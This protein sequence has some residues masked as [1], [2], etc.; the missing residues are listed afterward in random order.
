MCGGG[1][2]ADG[3]KLH[4]VAAR[5][6]GRLAESK[7]GEDRPDDADDQLREG[8]G[9]VRVDVAARLFV[10]DVVEGVADIPAPRRIRH[11]GEGRGR[12]G[13]GGS[14]HHAGRWYGSCFDYKLSTTERICAPQQERPQE[15]NLPH[16]GQPRPASESTFK[17][18]SSRHG[19]SPANT[20]GTM[21]F[22]EHYASYPASANELEILSESGLSR[23]LITAIVLAL[24]TSETVGR[25]ALLSSAC[26]MGSFAHVEPGSL[27]APC[28]PCAQV[29]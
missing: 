1:E 28:F 13:G 7:P 25:V 9:P 4:P 22:C 26:A 10:V 3:G 19:G 2:E 17:L 14:G 18:P 27:T 6:L 12:G 8:D 15:Q 5:N 11:G 23:P 16:H 29:R 20:P 21:Q 24:I